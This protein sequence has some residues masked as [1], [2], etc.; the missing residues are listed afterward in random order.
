MR[1]R[2]PDRR[3]AFRGSSRAEGKPW[4][5]DNLN[6]FLTKPKNYAQGTKMTCV[7]IKQPADRAIIFYLRGLSATPRPLE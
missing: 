5:Y 2:R 1:N 6:A 3:Q 7:G 4:T